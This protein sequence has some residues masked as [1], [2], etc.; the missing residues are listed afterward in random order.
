MAET[1]GDPTR[2]YGIPGIDDV[3]PSTGGGVQQQ[4]SSGGLSDLLA[5]LTAGNSLDRGMQQQQ[6]DI[7]KQQL[8]AQIDQAAQNYKLAQNADQRQAAL[9][10]IQKA[11]QALAQLQFEESKSQF[12]QTFGLQQKQQAA[13][14]SQFG[15]AQYSDL[16]KSLLGTAA[17]LSGP[18]NYANFMQ[19]VSGGKNLTDQLYG[20]TPRPTFQAPVGSNAPMTLETL[21][22]GL[23]LSGSGPT[24]TT[25][26][27]GN[28][29]AVPSPYQI[30]PNVWDSLGTTG[31]QMML[32][33]AAKQGWDPAEF[34]KQLNASRPTGA[35]PS[36]TTYNYGNP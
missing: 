7:S 8:Q 5:S 18:A 36:M 35:S 29:P 20:N 27:A 26:N 2:Q 31:Q 13:Q 6:I 19:Y 15:Q 10:D 4:S 34:Q 23:G 24:G 21:M 32:G 1:F 16:A 14:E 25:P 11:Q 22:Q 12:A 3:A 30:N 17:G 28:T 9:L 33:V